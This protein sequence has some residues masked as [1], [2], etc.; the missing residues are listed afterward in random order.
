MVMF[1]R[2]VWLWRTRKVESLE[3]RLVQHP[4]HKNPELKIEYGKYETRTKLE[5]EMAKLQNSIKE[6]THDIVMNQTLKNMK[7][8][9]K[10]LAFVTKEHV[11]T[12]KGRVACEISTCD[13]LLGT[14]LMFS[15]AFHNLS[16]EQLVALLSCLVFSEK[17]DG[18]AKLKEDLASP[19]R[20]MQ[21]S[22]RRIAQVISDARIQIDP[23]EYVNQ[24]QPQMM[25]VVFQ[26]C[27]G[28]KF[29]E[30]CKMTDIFEG[31]IIRCMR[32]LEELLRQFAT[33]ARAIG[34][35]S[36]E[37][38]FTSGMDKLK[39]DIAFAASLYL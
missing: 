16:V 14:E 39:R 29:A 21:E 30:I 8:V 7:R 26:W 27:K 20:Q 15:G 11:I 37:E 24:F 28:A 10:R 23:E 35:T 31:S 5:E 6:A 9:L 33:A 22:A 12:T 18:D 17:S 38:K 36:L 4:Y 13:E 3:D 2:L 34:D 32:R 19:L 25:D 1:T